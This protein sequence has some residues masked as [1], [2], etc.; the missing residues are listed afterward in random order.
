MSGKAKVTKR[1]INQARDH[2]LTLFEQVTRGMSK[3]Q[4]I[5][6]CDEIITDIEM[7]KDAESHNA[8]R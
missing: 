7:K 8:P 6:F 4:Y 3:T 1:S 2:V 5:D